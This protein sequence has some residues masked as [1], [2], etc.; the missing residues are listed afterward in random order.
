MGY[1]GPE[2][3]SNGVNVAILEAKLEDIVMRL[4][5][6]RND[7]KDHRTEENEY[8]EQIRAL[9]DKII[10]RQADMAEQCAVR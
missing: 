9:F 5:D 10:E 7:I 1:T 2:R 4:E 6:Y 3:R 8:K